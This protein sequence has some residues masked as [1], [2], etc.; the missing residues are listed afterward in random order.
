MG[1]AS[2]MAMGS[3]NNNRTGLNIEKEI[4]SGTGVPERG[5]AMTGGDSSQ[6]ML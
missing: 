4:L 3:N 5:S 6:M 1:K 2:G